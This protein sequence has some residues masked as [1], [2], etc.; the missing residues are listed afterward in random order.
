[1]RTASASV[2]AALSARSILSKLSA[3]VRIVSQTRNQ[4]PET[5]RGRVQRAIED[6][7]A[8]NFSEHRVCKPETSF[9]NQKPETRNQKPE[10]RNQKPETRRGRRSAR[11]RGFRSFQLQ[12]TLFS[13]PETR[14][15]KPE[16]GI[17]KPE[18]DFFLV[19]GFWF[20]VSGFYSSHFHISKSC[21]RRAVRD[22]HRLHRIAF[23]AVRQS[24][25]LP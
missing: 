17:E 24:P 7:E 13:K 19:S 14:M 25:H 22:A 4:K 16:T 1:M 23:A 21:R 20:L 3:S 18:G 9:V 6:F 5:R 12:C 2:F 11:D 15:G 10:T 8:F